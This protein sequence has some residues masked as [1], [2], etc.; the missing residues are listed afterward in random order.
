MYDERN[1]SQII[2]LSLSEIYVVQYAVKPEFENYK[3]RLL[4]R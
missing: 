3:Q 1:G 4:Q 2:S